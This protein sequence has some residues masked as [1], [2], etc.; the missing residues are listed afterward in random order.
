MITEKDIKTRISE[1][2]TDNGFNAVASEVKEGF[3]K[4]AVFVSVM[5]ASARLL[6][7]GGATEEIT[8]SVELKYITETETDEECIDAANK[9]KRIFLYNTF[10]IDDRHITV[11]EIEFDV[12]NSVLYTYFEITFIRIVETDEEY[13][14]MEALMIGGNV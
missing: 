14:A 3:R 2:L 12:E 7:C 1:I 8:D 4:P 10:D 11:S 9:F 5:P 6:T 13:E